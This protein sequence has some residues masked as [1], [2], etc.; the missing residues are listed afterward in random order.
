MDH[1]TKIT[2][3]VPVSQQMS[4]Y[5]NILPQFSTKSKFIVNK[6][7]HKL[8]KLNKKCISKQNRGFR[9]RTSSN[10][11]LYKN[12]N[13]HYCDTATKSESSDFL[14]HSDDSRASETNIS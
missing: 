12:K 14:E 11:Y 13:F 9:Y 4:T 3:W 6:C 5:L 10:Q 2:L 8:Q 1:T 7:I